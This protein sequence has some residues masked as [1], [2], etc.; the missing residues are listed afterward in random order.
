[1][2]QSPKAAASRYRQARLTFTMEASG[3][4]SYSLYAKPLNAAWDEHQ[5]LIRDSVVVERAPESLED[6]IRILL[7]V[8]G[9]QLLPGHIG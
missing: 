4:C 2:R 5:C 7:I 1:M 6:V 3:R 9:E 8:L